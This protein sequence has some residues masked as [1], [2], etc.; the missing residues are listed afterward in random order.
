MT[1]AKKREKKEENKIKQEIE[2]RKII[3]YC[4]SSETDNKTIYLL[5]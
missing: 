5:I 3:V 4:A 2:E 1:N